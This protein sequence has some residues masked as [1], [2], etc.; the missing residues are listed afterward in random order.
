[1]NRVPSLNIDQLQKHS[2]RQ[3]LLKEFLRPGA[4]CYQSSGILKN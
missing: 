3:N 2:E 1:M 4:D